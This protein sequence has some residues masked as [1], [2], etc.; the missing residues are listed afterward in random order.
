MKDNRGFHFL[1]GLASLWLG[2]RLHQSGVLHDIGLMAIDQPT[3]KGP[4]AIFVSF[5]I[6]GLIA[7]GAVMV[8]VLSGLLTFTPKGKINWTFGVLFT[9][10]D[11]VMI[12]VKGK[13]GVDPSLVV[14]F[15][16]RPYL[17]KPR[18]HLTHAT[19]RD[20]PFNPPE[21]YDTLRGNMSS[22]LAQQ[23]LEGDF[24]D[25]AGLMFSRAWFKSVAEAPM[26]ALRVRYWDK[27]CV[28]G[29]SKVATKEGDV[30]INK[31]KAGDFVHTRKGLRKVLHSGRTKFTK[32]LS[33]AFFD[34]GSELIGTPDH[35]V[36]DDR[37]S[38]W[39]ELQNLNSQSRVIRWPTNEIQSLN[40]SN[41]KDAGTRGNRQKM[42]REQLQSN[43]TSIATSTSGMASVRSSTSTDHCTET[44]GNQATGQ[45]PVAV[46]SITL[47]ATG[48]TTASTIFNACLN[49]NTTKSIGINS[50][51][52][53]CVQKL[54]QDLLEESR[55]EG[56]PVY[57]LTVEGQHEFFANGV[58]V[59]NCTAGSGSYT[60]GVLVAM[61]PRGMI[62]VE[63]VVRGQWS[64]HER[65]TIIEQTAERDH[66]KYKGEVVII[67]EQE[68]GSGG[69]EVM[70]QMI[71]KLGRFPVQRD[72]VG[73]KQTRFESGVTLPGQAKITR[74][75]PLAGQAEAGNVHLV[76]GAWNL[77]FL[78]ELVSFPES[79][80]ADQVDGVSGGY[81]RLAGKLFANRQPA[82][83]ES[84]AIVGT[85]RFGNLASLQRAR[86]RRLFGMGER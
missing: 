22:Q 47:T 83:K 84:A 35:L 4:G 59:H 31:V 68:G 20:N 10:V 24:I 75:M 49:E 3:M 66:R 76:K 11:E 50:R 78:E 30:R 85:E 15:G 18:T 71:T 23:E 62:Y 41:L 73:G 42:A 52:L 46:M 44:S 34:D 81:N 40:Q 27:A 53:T 80:Q 86:T 82:K 5:A 13:G 58:L 1:V 28:L 67:A 56:W 33:V 51:M 16:G 12:G 54:K 70:H 72:I 48:I 29:C 69:K 57:D 77:D 17:P 25:V 2:W 14:W 64:Y 21:F 19:S 61:C 39:I 9:E 74:A 45:Y 8:L 36:W 7:I 43:D 6:E 55:V 26:D 32:S 79:A 38:D 65:D 37:D 60:A 63:D